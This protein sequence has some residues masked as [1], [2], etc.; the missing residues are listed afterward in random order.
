[1]IGITNRTEK[2]EIVVAE[3]GGTISFYDYD[4]NHIFSFNNTFSE[5]TYISVID[6][7]LVVTSKD[8]VICSWKFNDRESKLGNRINQK[9]EDIKESHENDIKTSISNNIDVN[10]NQG[11]ADQDQ[12]S[13]LSPSKE[14]RKLVNEDTQSCMSEKEVVDEKQ[15]SLIPKKS[16]TA[17]KKL[18]VKSRILKED[19]TQV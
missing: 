14:L 1:M 16:G 3:K 9:E 10:S 4:G 18:K 6:K 13:E 8:G 5:I 17:K 2:N 19:D 11:Q 7:W 12:Q 15:E